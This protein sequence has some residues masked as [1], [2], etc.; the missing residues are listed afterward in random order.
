MTKPA[1]E[2][3]RTA[4]Q[5]AKSRVSI[6]VLALLIVGAIG[7]IVAVRSSFDDWTPG[8]YVTFGVLA[9]VGLLVAA[10]LVVAPATDNVRA[11]RAPKARARRTTKLATPDT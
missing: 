11:D 9:F 10:G 1:A 7:A 8:V 3:V 5:H 6:I 2:V 4:I